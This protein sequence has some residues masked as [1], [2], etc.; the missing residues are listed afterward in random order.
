MTKVVNKFDGETKLDLFGIE[1][2]MRL[3]ARV[4]AQFTSETG[5][6]LNS[7][8]ADLLNELNRLKSTGVMGKADEYAASEMMA[9]LCSVVDM[10]QAAWLFYLSAKEMDAMVTF[11]E[12]QEAVLCEGIGQNAR[13][14]P[15]G[16]L[17]TTYPQLFLQYT[18]FALGI[19][20]EDE[21][22]K[23]PSSKPS[24]LTRLRLALSS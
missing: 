3:N 5:R 21:G 17:V 18:I 24:L 12:I 23:K 10:E 6:D 14:K 11:E 2:P 19:G 1:Y 8:F 22:T 16:E 20:G 9:G 13:Y 7:I 4:Y 15:G